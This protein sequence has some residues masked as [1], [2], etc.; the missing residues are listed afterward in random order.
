MA[1][2]KTSKRNIPGVVTVNQRIVTRETT[3]TKAVRNQT[4][5]DVE[6]FRQLSQTMKE[7]KE[8][9]EAVRGRLLHTLQAT[10]QQRI[11]S[12]DGTFAVSLKERSN[13][14]YSDE[15][16]DRLTMLKAE[17]QN[18]QRKGIA[19]NTPTTYIDGRTVTA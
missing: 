9:M 13:W 19:I 1:A 15:L 17:Q 16:E 3:R 6:A 18:E 5:I 10:N 11:L 2:T 14:T 7:L 12:T 8:E 4:Q